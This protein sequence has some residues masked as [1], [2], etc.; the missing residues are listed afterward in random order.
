MEWLKSKN[1]SV[2]FDKSIRRCHPAGQV[3]GNGEIE[4]HY[5]RSNFR[6]ALLG[7]ILILGSWVMAVILISMIM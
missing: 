1:V 7:R 4:M 3:L 2:N 5:K 6:S